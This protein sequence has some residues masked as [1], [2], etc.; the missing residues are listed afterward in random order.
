VTGFVDP[1]SDLVKA[2]LV[3]KATRIAQGG[4]ERLVRE[5]EGGG[6]GADEVFAICQRV[7]G[8]A[9]ADDDHAVFTRMHEAVLQAI[10]ETKENNDG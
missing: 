3:E 2:V 4:I 6:L 1:Q 7:I 9:E 5:G 10:T 8:E